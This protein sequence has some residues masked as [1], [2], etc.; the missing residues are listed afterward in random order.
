MTTEPNNLR[1]HYLSASR[2]RQRQQFH[3]QCLIWL[4]LFAVAGIIAGCAAS[5]L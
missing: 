5:A 1:I 4:W 2:H 3:R